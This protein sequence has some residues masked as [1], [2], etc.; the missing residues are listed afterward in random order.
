MSPVRIGA[1]LR[2]FVVRDFRI[3]VSYRTSFALEIAT[4]VFLL[5]LF[6]YLSRIV[7]DSEIASEAGLDS[8]YF[9][10]AAIGLAVLRIV[11]V[12]TAS[13]SAKLRLEQTTGTFEALMATPASPSLIILASA[14]YELIR[15]TISGL[16]LLILAIVLFGLR[17][18]VDPASVGAA[19]LALV[20]LLGLFAALGVAVSA[21]TV[22]FKQTT[23][24]LG[25]ITAGLALLGG[26][27]FPVELLPEP[28]QA[29]AD[30]LPF[31]WGL[32]VMRGALLGGEVEPWRLAALFGSA[33]LL[34]P[35]ALLGF[36]AS[37]D[38]ARRNG[39]M[40]QY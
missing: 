33:A 35:V 5:A 26:V 31:T 14:C 23:A 8:S 28:V 1:V 21:F 7:D 40:S 36:R 13:F 22:V 17:L 15:A 4:N 20:G 3:A 34:L 38:H 2:A 29:I 12:S 11:Q 18:D 19:L 9:A 37:V 39:S 10:F 32:E 16:L 24:L 25:L 27:Y 30:L 6:Y